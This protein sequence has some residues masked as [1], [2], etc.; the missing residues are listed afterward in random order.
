[1]QV[2]AA[3]LSRW[4]GRFPASG[5]SLEFVWACLG[6]ATQC[7]Q[8]CT[9]FLCREGTGFVAWP[10]SFQG[11]LAQEYSG[12]LTPD[13]TS[14]GEERGQAPMCVPFLKF[15][16]QTPHVQEASMWG[17][18]LCPNILLAGHMGTTSLSREG[19]HLFTCVVWPFHPGTGSVQTVS[20]A[21]VSCLLFPG[22]MEAYQAPAPV[23][24]LGCLLHFPTPLR[25]PSVLWGRQA[26][27]PA[28][29]SIF[30]L[31]L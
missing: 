10:H 22:D 14:K 8:S 9:C 11:P 19:C 23:S 31:G 24:I 13:H 21:A 1:M 18:F 7:H 20:W 16:P 15:Q 12:P 2:A 28:A 3:W 25:G 27:L 30:C 26:L 6:R 4:L 29:V 5:I 17:F